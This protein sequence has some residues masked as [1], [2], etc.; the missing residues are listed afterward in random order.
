MANP[1][2]PFGFEPIKTDGKENS[3]VYYQKTSA[4][5]YRGDSVTMTA[6]GQIRSSV[7]GEQI[8]GVAAESNVAG[9]AA[10]TI[11]VYGDPSQEFMVQVDTFSQTDVPLNAD[12]VATAANTTLS[13]SKHS[14]NQATAAVTVTLQ[15]KILG[16]VSRGENATGAFA[17][18]KVKPN[19]HM[20]AAGSVA[21]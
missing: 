20:K 6:T 3:V 17:I 9:V 13:F 19:N 15:Y 18:I 21:I 12:I 4:S 11:A 14:I 10:Q 7:A 2:A 16:L 5:I 8:C 1:N